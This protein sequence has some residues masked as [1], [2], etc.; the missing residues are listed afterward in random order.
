M[1]EVSL[2]LVRLCREF[3]DWEKLNS[4]LALINKRSSQHKSTLSA[5]VKEAMEYLTLTPSV[6]VKINLIKALKEVCDGKIYVEGES[7]HLHFMLAAIYESQNDISSACDT[8][9]DVHV[10]TYGSLSKKEKATYIIEQIR[11]NLLQKDYIRTAIHSRKMNRKTIEEDEFEGIKVKFYTLQIEFFTYEKNAWEI[12]QSYYKIAQTKTGDHLS[13]EAKLFA[14]ESCVLYL[15]LSKRE[16]EQLQLLQKMKQ[17]LIT[18]FKEFELRASFVNGLRLFTT[19]EIIITPFAGQE[20]LLNHGSLS[21]YSNVHVDIVTHLVQQFNIRVIE[22]NLR[23]VSKYYQKIHFKR[24]QE[25]LNLSAD[26]LEQ[27][28]SNMSF[29]GDLNLKIDR[30]AGIISFQEKRSSEQILTEWSGDITKML[31]LME[32]TCHLINRENMVHKA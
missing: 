9:Q 25:L 12:C 22:H 20:E 21:R 19:N 11:L 15:L 27:H 13:T 8:I 16:N 10:E 14:L 18:D 5:V 26:E 7:A 23:V 1:R 6:E 2:Q 28:L 17:S 4:V 32:A 24:L 30:P 29:S 31:S 3:N